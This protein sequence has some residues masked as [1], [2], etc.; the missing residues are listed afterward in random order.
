LR[1]HVIHCELEAPGHT[2]N[3]SENV[4]PYLRLLPA[5]GSYIG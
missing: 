3:I 4:L 1:H 2:K 5:L